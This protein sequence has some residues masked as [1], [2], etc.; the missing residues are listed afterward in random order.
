[1]IGDIAAITAAAAFAVL[2][3]FLAVPLWKL[4]GVFS[5]L[6]RSI[7]EF[8]DETIVAVKQG[9]DSLDQVNAQ[10]ERVDSIT[11]AANRSVEDMSALTT[12][13]TATLGRPLIKVAAFSYA[14]RQAMGLHKGRQEEA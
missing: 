10:L 6:E 3:I 8:S 4:G 2:V 14:V 9:Q 7:K 5:Q 1:M 13:V 11:S 12:L